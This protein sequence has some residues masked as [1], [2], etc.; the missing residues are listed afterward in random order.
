MQCE[1]QYYK[2]QWIHDHEIL[3]NYKFHIYIV[4]EENIRAILR[5]FAIINVLNYH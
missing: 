1:I 5:K 2:V 4:A 3:T